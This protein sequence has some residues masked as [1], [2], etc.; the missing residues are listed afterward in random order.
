VAGAQ[1][2][3]MGVDEIRVQ[4]GG[5][6]R[7]RVHQL[8]RRPTFPRPVADLAQGRVWHADDIEAWIRRRP[9]T[10]SPRDRRASP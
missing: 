3:L 6:S 8:A 2:R 7:Q 1:I 9:P 10:G 5:I 4:L